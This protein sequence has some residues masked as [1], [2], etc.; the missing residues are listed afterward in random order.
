MSTRNATLERG[1]ATTEHGAVFRYEALAAGTRLAGYI[2]T[3]TEDDAEQIEALLQGRTLFFGKARTAGY[4]RAHVESVERLMDDAWREV[5][6]SGGS[7]SSDSTFTLTLLSDAIVRDYRGQYTLDPLPALRQRCGNG[8]ELTAGEDMIFRQTEVVG[9]FN[10]KWGLPL[11]QVTAIA[12]GS[13]FV[14]TATPAIPEAI[15]RQLEA[16]GIGERR[17]EGFGRIAIN[18]HAL[19][20]DY[21]PLAELTWVTLEPEAADL[22]TDGAQPPLHQ[23]QLSEDESRFARQLLTRII[24]HDLDRQLLDAVQTS[25]IHSAGPIPNSQLS[26]WRALVRSALTEPSPARRIGRLTEFLAHEEQKKSTA[27]ERM[28]RARVHFGGA[29][30]G[31]RLRLTEWTQQVLTDQQSPW[32]WFKN[33]TKPQPY[34][35]GEALQVEVDAA[36]TIEYRL[37]LL[38]GVLAR[39]AKEQAEGAKRGG[40]ND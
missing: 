29:D 39:K 2:L 21:L 27:W 28:W 13:V 9:G 8:C 33:S 3:A 26:R 10:R 16:E 14:I 31:E 24:R 19:S 37:R 20:E 17:V 30:S 23:L 15:L 38:D 1:R 22:T 18:W 7:L 40:G 32:K 4:G 34:Q 35:L 11:P 5:G 36:L 25:S 6:L 12:A